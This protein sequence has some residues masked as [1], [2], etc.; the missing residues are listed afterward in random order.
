MGF[1]EVLYY[2]KDAKGITL[3]KEGT[4]F[5]HCASIAEVQLTVKTIAESRDLRNA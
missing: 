4:G 5:T 3:K 1:G 2:Q